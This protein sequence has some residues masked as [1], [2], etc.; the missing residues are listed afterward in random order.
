MRRLLACCFLSIAAGSAT[1]QC[2]PPVY[3]VGQVWDDGSNA[4]VAR[5]I[6][7]DIHDFAPVGY[8]A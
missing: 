2:V 6:S 7:L 4:T 1:A 3:S 5:A 8:S